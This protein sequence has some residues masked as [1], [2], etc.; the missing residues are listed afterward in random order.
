L[1]FLKQDIFGFLKTS[2]SILYNSNTLNFYPYCFIHRILK[3][4]WK[5]MLVMSS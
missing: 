2:Q 4:R 1:D 3:E 5:V